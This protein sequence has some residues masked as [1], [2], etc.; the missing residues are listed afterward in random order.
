MLAYIVAYIIPSVL[1]LTK[2]DYSLYLSQSNKQDLQKAISKAF[3]LKISYAN[4]F[5]PIEIWV[6]KITL[7]CLP[8]AD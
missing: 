8:S 4:C 1:I 6:K 2:S 7:T 5:C 3:F